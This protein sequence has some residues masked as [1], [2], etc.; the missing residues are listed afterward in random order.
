[1]KKYCSVCK[2]YVSCKIILDKDKGIIIKLECFH[3]D[4]QNSTRRDGTDKDG[5]IYGCGGKNAFKG[6][7][8]AN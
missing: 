7:L 4:R 5:V 3:K 1:M 6:H 2:E 8:C